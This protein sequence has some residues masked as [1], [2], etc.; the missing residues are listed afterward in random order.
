MASI[1]ILV[2]LLAVY[3]VLTIMSLRNSGDRRYSAASSFALAALWA[4]LLVTGIVQKT[5]SGA[6]F[7]AFLV[8]EAL[9]I[10]LNV[11]TGFITLKTK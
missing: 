11:I 6:W 10:V 1:I 8:L 3:A 7:W 9:L 5:A 2:V 4:G